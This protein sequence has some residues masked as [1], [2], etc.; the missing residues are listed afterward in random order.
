MDREEQLRK[1][2]ERDYTVNYCLYSFSVGIHV[3][4]IY[5]TAYI[6]YTVHCMQ[7]VLY[8][9]QAAALQACLMMLI[10]SV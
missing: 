4:A 3:V 7:F 9:V 10:A 8:S 5:H 1:R 6:L 2:R